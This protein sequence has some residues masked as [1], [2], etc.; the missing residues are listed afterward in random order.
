M[1]CLRMITVS[2]SKMPASI[3]ES[4]RTSSAKCSPPPS[5]SGGTEMVWEC[6]WIASIGVPAAMRPMTGMETGRPASEMPGIDGAA[7]ARRGGDTAETAIDDARLEPALAAAQRGVHR[8]GQLDHFERARPVGQAAD[9]AALLECGDQPVNARFAAQIERV[10]HFIEGGRDAALLHPLVDEHEEF[11][12]L[13]RE[14][15]LVPQ[16]NRNK[17]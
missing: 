16:G 14:H 17:D 12:L 11:M 8:I 15:R 9:E 7:L 13:A 1:S 2:P 3:I 10:L 6:V 4:P 5:I